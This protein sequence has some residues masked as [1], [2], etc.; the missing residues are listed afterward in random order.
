MLELED[1]HDF[2][3]YDQKMLPYE[4]KIFTEEDYDAIRKH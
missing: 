1:I 3:F 4:E 2:D